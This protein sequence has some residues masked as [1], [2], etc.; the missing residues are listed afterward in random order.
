MVAFS[1]KRFEKLFALIVVLLLA[2]PASTARAATL[3]F[4]ETGQCVGD[5]FGDFWQGNGG[6]PVFGFPIVAMIPEANVDTGRTHVAQWLERE[7]LELHPEN[8]QPYAILL[9][10][11]GVER[12]GQ[13]GRDWTTFPRANASAPHYYAVTGHAIAPQFW[14]YWRGHGLDLGD[15]GLSERESLALFGYPLSEPSMERNQAGDTVLTQWFERARFE[16]HP[17]N[18]E[19]YKVLLG[20]LGR[21]TMGAGNPAA[22]PRYEDRMGVAQTML[23][24]YNAVNR[25]EYRRAYGYWDAPGTSPTSTPPD[26]ATFE[27]GYATTAYVAVTTGTPSLDAGAG[28][29]WATVPTVIVATTTGGRREVF[30]GCYVLHHTNPGAD[31]RPDAELWKLNRARIDAARSDATPA[32]LLAGLRCDPGTIPPPA[33]T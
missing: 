12:L 4:M 16:Y 22:S 27:Q 10:R 1:G 2:S 30:S 24:Y 18:P 29:F 14:E 7:R 6:L 31:P 8:R 9:G 3:C 5:P 15:Q 33:T 26:Y 28:N 19:P 23:S 11:L 21:E 25:K 17:D 20:L 13:L 32:A